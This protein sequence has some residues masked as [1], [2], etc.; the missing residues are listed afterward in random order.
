MSTLPANLA[1]NPLL[2]RWVTIDKADTI[3]VRSGKVEL[4][5]GIAT[6]MAAIAAKELGLTLD[7]IRVEAASTAQGPDEGYTAGSFSVEHGGS[8]MRT[9]CGMVRTL[10]EQRAA[11]KLGTTADA[12]FVAN[13]LFTKAH[14]NESVSYWQLRDSIDLNRS[15]VDLPAPLL[16]S[17]P[18]DQSQL[19]RTDL[20]AKFSGAAFIQDMRLPG[21][22]Y[23]RVLRPNHPKARLVSVDEAVIKAQPGVAH[24]VI[25]GGFVGVVA[26]RDEDAVHAI[27][28]AAKTAVWARTSELPAYDG[29]NGWMAAV[30]PRSSTAF[31]DDAGEASAA[32]QHHSASYSIRCAARSPARSAW[33]TRRCS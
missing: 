33:T 26:A 11:A 30:S 7:Q 18:V 5:Q 20:P 24:V 12:V 22:L 19:Q 32:H 27:A 13:G 29:S 15:A 28:K 17:G 14:S 9:A 2:N 23:G 10:F 25:D 6:A 1:A 16:R 21:Q 3:T 31:L 4:G 8:A